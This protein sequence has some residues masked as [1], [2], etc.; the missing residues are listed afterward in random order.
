MTIKGSFSIS[1][2]ISNRKNADIVKLI[3]DISPYQKSSLVISDNELTVI[4]IPSDKDIDLIPQI[5]KMIGEEHIVNGRVVWGDGEP[6]VM[7][8]KNNNFS[9]YYFNSYDYGRHFLKSGPEFV[10]L[11]SDFE[12][13][14]IFN[15]YRNENNY[16][17]HI[18]DNE[19]NSNIIKY[20]NDGKV[21]KTSTDKIII[22]EDE[23]YYFKIKIGDEYLRNLV[24]FKML[25]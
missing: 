13:D 20:G 11:L 14:F 22:E 4:D 9:I 6:T 15:F 19:F 21:I 10:L 17:I 18:L 7:I 16:I 24:I 23:G 25:I 2:E 1:P 12:A 8:V 3:D 5:V